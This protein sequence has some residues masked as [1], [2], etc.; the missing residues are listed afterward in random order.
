[1][2]RLRTV[3]I[4][5]FAGLVSGQTFQGCYNS[6]GSMVS[7][8]TYTWQ[9]KSHCST[10]CSA[11]GYS[12][13]ATHNGNECYCGNSLPPSSD[14]VDQNQCNVVC[15]GYGNEMC[16]SASTFSV[17]SIAD[18]TSTDPDT[19][20]SSAAGS[21]AT[22]GSSTSPSGSST[23]SSVSSASASNPSGSGS[24]STK[25]SSSDTSSASG[26]STSPS[27]SSSQSSQSSSS[28]SSS[29]SSSSSSASSASDSSSSGKTT[30]SANKNHGSKIS[31]GAIAG[32]VIGVVAALAIIGATLVFLKK[33]RSSYDHY[34]PSTS[35]DR[36][37]EPFG[38]RPPDLPFGGPP[39]RYGMSSDE[40]LAA[41]AGHQIDQRLN[42]VMLGERRISV[43]SLADARDYS[44]KILRVANPDDDA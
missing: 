21:S 19:S 41:G 33:R 1:M 32:I 15:T 36:F 18:T 11:L 3:A 12:I 6:A 10:A 30:A 31:G 22:G 27:L 26:S 4:A 43:G 37:K 42:P 24:S 34:S 20:S 5:A 16:G 9:S 25:T 39:P 35:P 23:A 29:A 38:V 14:K 2:V 13:I 44:R 28:Q 40:A 7:N 17:Y 8:G